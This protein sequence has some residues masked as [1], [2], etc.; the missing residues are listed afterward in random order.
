MASIDTNKNLIITKLNTVSALKYVYSYRRSHYD[1]FPCAVVSL[2]GFESEYADN[3]RDLRRYTYTIQVIQEREQENFGAQKGERVL[4]EAIDDIMTVIDQDSNF[5][6]SDI[7]YSDPFNTEI[8][9]DG[10]Y[11]IAT[12]TVIMKSLINTTV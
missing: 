6:G 10:E 1:G 8:T 11:L 9:E 5:S 4:A 12:I 7:T 2:Q 3:A